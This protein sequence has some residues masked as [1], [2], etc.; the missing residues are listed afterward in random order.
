MFGNCSY[1]YCNEDALDCLIACLQIELSSRPA[2]LIWK[3]SS[4]VCCC[5]F[6]EGCGRK[7]WIYLGCYGRI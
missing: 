7:C 5:V 3:C 4:F 1:I 6:P 2:Y